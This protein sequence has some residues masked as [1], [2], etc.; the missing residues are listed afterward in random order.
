MDTEKKSVFVDIDKTV[1]YYDE[2]TLDYTLA[3][4][5]YK[6][7]DIV[8]RLYDRFNVVMWTARGAK[9]GID[10]YDV[11]KKQLDSWGVKY[12]KLRLDKPAYD[13][14]VWDDV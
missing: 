13:L 9:S 5:D 8:N 3:K 14:L 12:H 4:P 1:C 10:W 11:T 6:R 7:I 2:D